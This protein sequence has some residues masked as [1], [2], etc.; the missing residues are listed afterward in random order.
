[1]P[2]GLLAPGVLGGQGLLPLLLVLLL[3]ELCLGLLSLSGLLLLLEHRLV[4][5][6]GLLLLLEHRLTTLRLLSGRL[7]M[8]LLAAGLVLLEVELVFLGL[9]APRGLGLL[10]VLGEA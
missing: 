3:P 9:L 2:G 7:L 5:L 1:M 6:S 10:A 8:L 4:M